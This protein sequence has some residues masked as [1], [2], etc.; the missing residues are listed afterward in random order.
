MFKPNVVTSG[1]LMT[2]N[3]IKVVKKKKN[4]KET[5]AKTA[6]N[7]MF[8]A[9]K[10]LSY[11][12]PAAV[13][14]RAEER[15]SQRVQDQSAA[16]TRKSN[17]MTAS[18]LKRKV[19]DAEKFHK[20]A[21]KNR[22]KATGSAVDRLNYNTGGLTAARE[23]AAKKEASDGC[24]SNPGGKYTGNICKPKAGGYYKKVNKKVQKRSVENNPGMKKGFPPPK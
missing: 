8:A 19:N 4:S 9:P 21:G 5:S 15:S 10:K 17:P 3:K 1:L 24:L 2:G 14:R 22:K 12:D 6:D 7:T 16:N 18:Q 13:Q 11:N 20:K 23:K